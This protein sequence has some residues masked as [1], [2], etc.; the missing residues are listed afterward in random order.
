MHGMHETEEHLANRSRRHATPAR[1]DLSLAMEAHAGAPLRTDGTLS[2]RLLAEQGDGHDTAVLSV[3][4][5]IDI[6][7]A[8]VL[9]DALLPVLEQQTG[10]VVVDLSDVAFMDS[11]GVHVLVDAL[12]RAELENRRLAVACRE[13]GHV[14]RLLGL[15]GLLDALA[16]YRS[17]ERAV[18]GGDDLLR[19]EPDRT[20]FASAAPRLT[21]SPPSNSPTND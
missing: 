16:V 5:E 10:P 1:L 19:S 4:G 11:T 9:R 13:G 15:V 20:P 18:I 8:P 21:Q 7:T 12:Q 6:G 2:V 17:R 3:Y 14:H